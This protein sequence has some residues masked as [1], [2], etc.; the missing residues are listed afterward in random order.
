MPLAAAAALVIAGDS[1]AQATP[2][3]VRTML[4]D[5]AGVSLAILVGTTLR[6]QTPRVRRCRLQSI[7]KLVLKNKNLF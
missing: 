6:V 1:M 5:F 3:N 2:F 4:A 7:P